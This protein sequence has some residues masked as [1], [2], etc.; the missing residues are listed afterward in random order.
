MRDKSSY[1]ALL[2]DLTEGSDSYCREEL[3]TGLLGGA[4][5]YLSISVF[6]F[7]HTALCSLFLSSSHMVSQ[8][9]PSPHPACSHCSLIL[10]AFLRHT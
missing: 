8:S 10:S 5:K 2:N 6:F 1:C 9:Y 3:L 7:L 4:E